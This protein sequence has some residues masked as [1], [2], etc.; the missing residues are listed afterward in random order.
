MRHTSSVLVETSRCAHV[1]HGHV[2]ATRLN[3]ESLEVPADRAQRR[4]RITLRDDCD[5]HSLEQI[6][7]QMHKLVNVLRVTELAPGESLERELALLKVSAPRARARADGARRRLRRPRS[8]TSD[9]TRSCS[10]STGSPEE[11]D[12]FEEL[13]RPHGLQELVRTGR[14]G[15][16][17]RDAR[18][19]GQ[20]VAASS[21]L[22]HDKELNPMATIDRDGDLD[23]L[24]GKVAVVGYGSQGHAHALNLHDSG[25]DVAVGL[26]EG[27][28]RARRPRRRG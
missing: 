18:T 12:S 19:R 1:C 21:R 13:V 17:P 4:S 14:I 6:E 9:P 22:T 28:R 5:T 23:L 27:S 2:R 25:V 16:H 15:L 8:P 3:I 7:K 11:V 24:D 26:R 10:S 20:G